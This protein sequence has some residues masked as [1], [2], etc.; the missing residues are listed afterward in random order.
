M[1][2]ES[3]MQLVTEVLGDNY[4]DI[5][6]EKYSF[7]ESVDDHACTVDF[8]VTGLF[9]NEPR[10]IHGTGVGFVDAAFHAL[11]SVLA[12][13]YPSLKSIRFAGFE[14]HGDLKTSRENSGSDAMGQV[15]LIVENSRGRRFDFAHRSR[16]LT[17]SAIIAT[18]QACEYFVNTERAFIS[19]HRALVDA[20]E[21]NRPQLVEKYRIQM[22][23]IVENTSYSEVIERLTES[24]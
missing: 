24:K 21:R 16:S 17:A 1:V 15:V 6:I 19:L 11:H 14:V 12:E 2:Q 10:K 5:H 4:L 9:A 20:K 18:V 7:E 23:T 8:L 3:T 22:A 13:E